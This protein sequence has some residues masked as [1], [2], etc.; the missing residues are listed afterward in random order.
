MK[1]AETHTDRLVEVESAIRREHVNLGCAKRVG[2][3]ED[4]LTVV[5]PALVGAVREAE[6]QEMPRK[7]VV[8]LGDS[9]EI[10]KLGSFR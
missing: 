10:L 2:A 6:D 9:V 8:L 1:V 3:R 5:E 7:D 4:E